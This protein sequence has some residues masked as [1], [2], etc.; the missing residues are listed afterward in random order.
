MNNYLPPDSAWHAEENVYGIA[1]EYKEQ[2]AAIIR[3]YFFNVHG[4]TIQAIAGLLGNADLESSL[5]PWIWQTGSYPD[6]WETTGRGFGLTQW[7]PGRVYLNWAGGGAY[8]FGHWSRQLE[9]WGEEFLHNPYDLN[10]WLKWS[11]EVPEGYPSEIFQI[12]YRQ[13]ANAYDPITGKSGDEGL[14]AGMCGVIFWL[15]YGRPSQSSAVDPT[16]AN[17]R[18]TYA[19]RWETWL[20]DNPP[21]K[22]VPVWLIPIL[23]NNGGATAY[24]NSSH[25]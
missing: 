10:M 11:H 7:T 6:D 17:T 8:Q 1:R 5:N 3:D 21:K 22:H 14:S 12:T 20:H 18:N 9:C 23:K 15:N 13:Y 25:L 4:W 19:T 24:G 2:N 16:R